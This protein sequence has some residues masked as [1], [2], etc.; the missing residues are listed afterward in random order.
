M[1]DGRATRELTVSGT[2]IVGRDPSCDISYA[3]PRLSRKHAE[4]VIAADGVKVRDL[5]SRNGVLVNGIQVR[6]AILR[7]GDVVHIA[8]L[9]M[10]FVDDAEDGADVT[11]LRPSSR[12]VRPRGDDRIRALPERV[13]NE[14]VSGILPFAAG[15]LPIASAGDLS[16]SSLLATGWGR[17]AMLQ[18]LLLALTVFFVTALPLVAWYSRLAGEGGLRGLLVVLALPFIA[19]VAA[20]V[21]VAPLIVRTAVRGLKHGVRATRDS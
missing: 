11:V 4:I 21:M 18:G 8:H 2:V 13:M 19:A 14:R 10:T 9:A 7:P 12:V 20:G 1:D 15:D 3:D 16:M 5:E 17:R 6:E